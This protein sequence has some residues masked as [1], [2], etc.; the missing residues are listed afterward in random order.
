MAKYWKILDSYGSK[1]KTSR[2]ETEEEE[3]YRCGYED[4]FADAM[5]E[6]YDDEEEIGYRTSPHIRTRRNELAGERRGMS[7]RKSR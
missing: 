4:G 3:A 6:V 2:E 7:M 1:P 5:S